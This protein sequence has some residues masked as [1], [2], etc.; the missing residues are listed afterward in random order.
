MSVRW[1]N[2]FTPRVK[3][4]P[5][6]GATLRRLSALDGWF[7]PDMYV[8]EKCGYKGSVYVEAEDHEPE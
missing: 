7:L 4:C 5:K 6:C 2:P 8:C 3:L 1:R